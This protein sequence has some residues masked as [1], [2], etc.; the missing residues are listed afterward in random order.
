MTS[1]YYQQLNKE[2]INIGS[3]SNI[4]VPNGARIMDHYLSIA[5]Q[6]ER[7]DDYKQAKETASINA[8]N[9]KEEELNKQNENINTLAIMATYQKGLE[10]LNS[11][12]LS[13]PKNREIYQ[14]TYKNLLAQ[15]NQLLA[16][17]GNK[18]IALQAINNSSTEFKQNY[19][20]KVA[21]DTL[22]KY[23]TEFTKLHSTLGPSEAWDKI[24]QQYQQDINTVKDQ[25][26]KLGIMQAFMKLKQTTSDDEVNE[27][28]KAFNENLQQSHA[29]VL[30]AIDT[31][32]SSGIQFN[33]VYR[34]PIKYKQDLQKAHDYAIKHNL[35]SQ[36]EKLLL[37][38][39]Q[40]EK[41]NKLT[42]YS[43]GSNAYVNSNNKNTQLFIDAVT[44]TT[45]K[46]PDIKISKL[47]VTVKGNTIY[48][49]TLDTEYAADLLAGSNPY[50]KQYKLKNY[51][52]NN[53]TPKEYALEVLKL[54]NTTVNKLDEAIK[55]H[56]NLKNI[57][58][59]TYQLYA[60]YKD[61]YDLTKGTN[62]VFVVPE[63]KLLN[64]NSDKIQI[65]DNVF[66]PKNAIRKIDVNGVPTY[67][68]TS[69]DIQ[70]YSNGKDITVKGKTIVNGT[71]ILKNNIKIPN[72]EI[73][74][75]AHTQDVTSLSLFHTFLGSATNAKTKKQ[76]TNAYIMTHPEKYL[77]TK[78]NIFKN[79]YEFYKKKNPNIS[80]QDYFENVY[81]PAYLT[82]VKYARPYYNA[83]R[84][85]DDIPGIEMNVPTSDI[86]KMRQADYTFKIKPNEIL[87][88]SKSA[89][90]F[91]R[92][93][94]FIASKNGNPIQGIDK[95]MRLA[96]NNPEQFRAK[97]FQLT[98]KTPGC[99]V[100]GTLETECI[101]TFEG[102]SDMIDGLRDKE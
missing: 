25:D 31:L 4:N 54:D 59:N 80:E 93:L 68:I 41:P 36:T 5:N 62:Q 45:Q 77:N 98:K 22:T 66:I 71:I 81:K 48:I 83:K 89:V 64:T 69:T 21:N 11:L 49:P 10:Q 1:N 33:K 94:N 56:T 30:T 84:L 12:D 2:Q 72:Y 27:K 19:M 32:K 44:E 9:R 60:A 76:I 24:Y 70:K 99:K 100:M 63:T 46:N 34:D 7:N 42:N 53:V 90:K 14:Q 52:E 8:Y 79:Y 101:T 6:L 92:V 38:Y 50:V 82:A 102:L 40:Y 3:A 65:G 43:S 28:N 39:L 74:E 57:N 29:K 26:T 78:N 20:N 15:K 61:Y 88:S 47:P 73:V 51:V 58:P 96:K 91:L 13:D 97:F 75:P 95:L 55:N 85:A 67:Y 86:S 37:S 18:N 16:N 23:A 35:D 87:K 17:A